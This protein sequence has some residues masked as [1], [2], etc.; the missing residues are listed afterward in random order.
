MLGQSTARIVEW[1][2]VVYEYCAGRHGLAS[3]IGNRRILDCV[4]TL[5]GD[6]A[7]VDELE[8]AWS[9]F[10]RIPEIFVPVSEDSDLVDHRSKYVGQADIQ[11][12]GRIVRGFTRR[13]SLDR[14]VQGVVINQGVDA[15]GA[16]VNRKGGAERPDVARRI[17]DAGGIRI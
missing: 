5:G 14:P 7:G 10:R 8:S 9:S 13:Q 11:R 6:G 2:V 15:Q 3:H 1:L 12:R 17:D 16:D 4:R